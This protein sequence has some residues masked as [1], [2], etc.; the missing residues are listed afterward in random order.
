MPMRRGC[1][2]SVRTLCGLLVATLASTATAQQLPDFDE[3]APEGTRTV[4][5]LTGGDNRG[6]DTHLFRP[7]LDSKPNGHCLPWLVICGFSLQDTLT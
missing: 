5:P 1:L 2:G 4:G 3:R 6:A 7:A